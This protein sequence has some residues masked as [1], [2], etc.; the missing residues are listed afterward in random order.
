LE[1]KLQAVYRECS[2]LYIDENGREVYTYNHS[3]AAYYESLIEDYEKMLA[4]VICYKLTICLMKL[5]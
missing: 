5:E 1:L 4:S 2:Y 3:K